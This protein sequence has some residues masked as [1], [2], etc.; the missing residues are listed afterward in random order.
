MSSRYWLE[1]YVTTKTEAM[2]KFAVKMLK[3]SGDFLFSV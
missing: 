3:N 1:I 2:K